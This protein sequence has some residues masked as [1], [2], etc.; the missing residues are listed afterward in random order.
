MVAST[1]STTLFHKKTL[2]LICIEEDLLLSVLESTAWEHKLTDWE[3]LRG[4]APCFWSIFILLWPHSP[5]VTWLELAGWM[6]VT[7][8]M[9]MLSAGGYPSSIITENPGPY[10]LH[11]EFWFFKSLSNLLNLSLE[12]FSVTTFYCLVG[13]SFY[14]AFFTKI[15]CFYD[16]KMENV[17]FRAFGKGWKNKAKM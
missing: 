12:V 6:P 13:L 11:L 7:K 16:Y 4:G 17:D 9:K 14:N 15:L 8:W 10:T 3:A 5:S 1:S 2:K